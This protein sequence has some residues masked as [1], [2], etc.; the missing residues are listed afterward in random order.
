M[1][2]I[3][4]SFTLVWLRLG[5]LWAQPYAV[6]ATLHL[7]PPITPY[8]EELT[9]TFPNPLQLN[10]I[11]KDQDE[12]AYPVRL[13][14][15]ISGQGISIRTRKDISLPP[16]LLDYGIP[17]QLTGADLMN[18]FLPEQLE[19]QGIS[20]MQFSQRGGRLPE[21][22]Y[23]FCVEVLD[24]QRFRGVPI[25]NQSC[26]VVEMEELPPPL[27]L[28]PV[29]QVE[30]SQAQN[31]FIQW[32]PQHIANVT[33]QY[34]LRLWEIRAGLSLNQVRQQ[35]PPIFEQEIGSH[36]SFLY[37]LDAPPLLPGS[38]YIVQVQVEDLLEQHHFTNDGYSELVQFTYGATES[39]NTSPP[40]DPCGL[41]LKVTKP[42][43][44]NFTASW[45]SHP[46]SETYLLSLARD[47]LF[48]ELLPGFEALPTVDTF[49]RLQGLPEDGLV[50]LRVAMR[51][52]DCLPITSNTVSFFLGKGCLPLPDEELT[53]ACGTT[54]DPTIILHSNELLQELQSEDTIRAHDFQVIVQ[55][56]QGSGRFSGEGYVFI[57]YLKQARVNLAFS[58]IEVDAFCRLVSGKMEVSGAGLTVI[59]EELTGTIDSILHALE[60]LD[61]GLVEVE[62]ILEDAADFLAELEDI[63][64]YLANGQHVLENLLHLEE[65]FPYLPPD[66]I[67]AIQDA[68]DCLEAAQSAAAFEDCKVQMLAAIDELK[69]AMKIL[70]DADYRVNFAALDKQQFGFDT[71]R[72]PAH[73]EL[74]NKIP[75]TGTDYWIPWQSI[76]SQ[77]TATVKARA[78]SH[79]PFPETIQFKNQLKQEISHTESP[80]PHSRYLHL[81]GSGHQQTETIYAL[82]PYPDSLEQDQVHIAGQLS[83]ISYDP[84]PLKVVLVPIN[85]TQYPHDIDTLK[86]RLQ[87]IFSQAI[88]N[89]EL[90]THPGLS[91]TEF[92]NLL[93]SV[94][95]GFLANYN[96]EMQLIR[97]RFQADNTI[98]EDTYY[99]FLVEDSE[100]SQKLGYLP[101]K[102]HFGFIYHDNQGSEQQYIKTIA[103]E[104]GHGAYH[105]D[106]SFHDFPSLPP[107]Q[108]DNLMDYALGIHL[109]KYQWD[110]IHN[111]AA[112][113]TLFDGDEEGEME[114][115]ISYMVE[116]SFN[117]RCG[118]IVESDY[119]SISNYG[120]QSF[121]T[122]S[123][124]AAQVTDEMTHLRF[125]KDGLGYVI[126][127]R[128][129]RK[130]IINGQEVNEYH[131]YVQ[132]LTKETNTGGTEARRSFW[133]YINCNLYGDGPRQV[134]HSDNWLDARDIIEDNGGFY[135]LS[136]TSLGGEVYAFGNMVLAD[137]DLIESCICHF[138]FDYKEFEGNQNWIGDISTYPI[139]IPYFAPSTYMECPEDC[140]DIINQVPGDIG[141]QIYVFLHEDIQEDSLAELQN[142]ANYLHA[143]VEGKSFAFYGHQL[144]HVGVQVNFSLDVLRFFRENKIFN[145][146]RFRTFFPLHSDYARDCDII[147]SNAKLREDI[148]PNYNEKTVDHVRPGREYEYS[149]TDLV[150]RQNLRSV[151]PSV[152]YKAVKDFEQAQEAIPIS[153]K[154]GTEQYLAIFGTNHAMFA[155]LQYFFNV[156]ADVYD[157]V[158]AGQIV[159]QLSSFFTPGAL[160]DAQKFLKLKKS[161]EVIKVK[162]ETVRAGKIAEAVGSITDEAL[163]SLAHQIKSSHTAI[164]DLELDQV[165]HKLYIYS[166][167]PAGLGKGG[168]ETIATLEKKANTD[169]LVIKETEFYPTNEFPSLPGTKIQADH[170]V[171]SRG[172]YLEE[173]ELVTRE[174]GTIVFRAAIDRIRN[175]LK[176]IGASDE[177]IDRIKAIDNAQ[178]L[179]DDILDSHELLGYLEGKVNGVTI[180]ETIDGLVIPGDDTFKRLRSEPDFLNKFEEVAND[181]SLNE[182]IFTGEVKPVIDPTTGL[183]KVAPDGTK[184]WNVS[185]AHSK[186]SLVSNKLRI[187]GDKPPPNPGSTG[188]YTAKIEASVSAFTGEHYMPNGGWKVK[189]SPSTFFPDSWSIIKIQAEI[190][191]VLNNRFAILQINSE[192]NKLLGGTMSNGVSLRIWQHADGSFI[193][194]FPRL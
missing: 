166:P 53:Y 23:N 35:T 28:A 143:L 17:I 151:S 131:D 57:P 72:H 168:F 88:V 76:R 44:P 115:V 56:V 89:V 92:D 190:S 36:T 155:W 12:Q 33:P 95:S 127:F 19:F 90:Q 43:S 70:Y 147:F 153:T 48:Q 116:A 167:R 91:I 93:D 111:P 32:I 175:Q 75:I 162:L 42:Q 47:S 66:V 31:I 55:N 80:L 103:H 85:G 15:S 183:Q 78:T 150:K 54:V 160:N 52:N 6:D 154:D 71:I 181:I 83:V 46:I 2:K 118:S 86:A 11:L 122:P 138:R 156:A 109:Q 158:A 24:Y 69:E 106:H 132:C 37:G 7:Q 173:V 8:L 104:L 102:K 10:L 120:I 81:N 77:G 97:N 101:Q 99:L 84:I 112:N 171:S 113:W 38:R 135:T 133:G 64:D 137:H 26:S 192:G 130:V 170:I 100:H 157:P 119:I 176:A 193:S 182:H 16:I 144:E 128:V 159:R 73:S 13:H 65:H 21:G 25:S 79:D 177:L 178:A 186:T 40:D 129:R 105:L 3:A 117:T 87:S 108:T 4:L 141:G 134:K 188:F 62:S 146:D 58:N 94:P 49:Y 164:L 139:Y 41:S 74:Y 136:E 98:E 185:G 9:Q 145:I 18:Y 148:P 169:I 174:D 30:V 34:T 121:L 20:P 126:G 184:Q 60:I 61:A 14:F 22:I 51:S 191:Q 152:L 45:N 187:K 5:L 194:A 165:T 149:H 180:W 163:Q 107:G 161:T 114:G 59:S 1:E 189:Q 110:L 63:E 68:L 142:L 27:I 172:D 124:V 179:T 82:Q 39:T 67:K 50:Y 29:G 140:E 96:N 125:N 123:G